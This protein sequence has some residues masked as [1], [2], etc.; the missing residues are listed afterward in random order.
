MKVP[1]HGTIETVPKPS[2]SHLA[3]QVVS[4]WTIRLVIAGVMVAG[5][6]SLFVFPL[7]DYVTQRSA[8]AQKNSEFNLLA[9]TNE[10]LQN[11]VNDLS[12]P[13]GIRNAARAQLG[14]VRPGEQ[15][16][17][18]VPMPALPTD[19]PQT[20]PYTLV[21]DIVRVRTVQN[22]AANNSSLSPLAP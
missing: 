11:E 17:N 12:T 15:R 8:L 1:S 7:R 16:F 10:Q 6:A 14:Y 20:W 5:A 19:L 4:R 13:E 9:D 21:T 18:L 2:I 22:T 3:T